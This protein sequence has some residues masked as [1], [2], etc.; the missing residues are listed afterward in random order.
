MI[1]LGDVFIGSAEGWREI[2]PQLTGRKMLVRGNHDRQ[3]SLTWWMENG[4]DGAVD[5]MI[6]RRM[7]LTHEPAKF[8]PDGCELN[9]H[10][11]LHNIWHGFQPEGQP[12]ERKL[13]NEWQRLFAVE[14][15]GYAP[16]EFEKFWRQPDKFN[17]RGL[18]SRKACGSEEIAESEPASEVG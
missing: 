13:H 1:H 2:W 11:H 10:G 6:F 4:F 14:Y 15:T 8:L 12:I 18:T 5:S 9:I 17:A 7:W 3:R 16:V